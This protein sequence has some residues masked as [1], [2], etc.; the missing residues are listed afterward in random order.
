MATQLDNVVEA[1]QSERLATGLLFTKGRCGTLRA[2]AV[3]R[4]SRQ[5]DLPTGCPVAS[6]DLRE[7]SGSSN[8]MTFDRQGP[9][10]HL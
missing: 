6:R 5:S 7:Q 8:G 10:T 9:A 2:M 4:R 1:S 3:R